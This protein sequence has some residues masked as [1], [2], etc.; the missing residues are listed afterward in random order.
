MDSLHPQTTHVNFAQH[1]GA[2]SEDRLQELLNPGAPVFA[3]TQLCMSVSQSASDTGRQGQLVIP[4]WVT[5]GSLRV[6]TY[7]YADSV[8]LI[9]IFPMN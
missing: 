9:H 8:R 1:A 2:S 7:C 5:H 4:A 3:P 6:K